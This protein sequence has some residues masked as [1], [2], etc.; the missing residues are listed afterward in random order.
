[1]AA[2]TARPV[3]R[4]FLS[5]K[6]DL[7]QHPNYKLTGDYNKQNMFD[8]EKYLDRHLK[9]KP[10]DTYDVMDADTLSPMNP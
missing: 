8:I 4:P 6:Y 3:V 10:S 5:D 2:N 1:M 7:T 9:L